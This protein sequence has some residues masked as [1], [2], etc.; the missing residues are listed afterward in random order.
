M[1]AKPANLLMASDPDGCEQLKRLVNGE[2]ATTMVVVLAKT[3]EQDS[4]VNKE[5][6]ESKPRMDPRLLMALRTGNLAMLEQ[7]LTDDGQQRQAVGSNGEEG[8]WNDPSIRAGT[9][10]TSSLRVGVVAAPA[11]GHGLRNGNAGIFSS[12]ELDDYG[13]ANSGE[14]AHH[15]KFSRGSSSGGNSNAGGADNT[16][17]L[18]LNGVTFDSEGDSALHVLAAAG[19]TKQYLKCAEIIYGRAK[20]LLQEIN[21]EDTPVHCAARA[22]NRNMVSCLIEMAASENNGAVR[23]ELLRKRNKI[24]DTSLHSA[25][26]SGNIQLIQMLIW[27]DPELACIPY[28]GTSPLYLAISASELCLHCVLQSF[29]ISYGFSTSGPNGQ[30][31]LHTAVFRDVV[32][33]KALRDVLEWLPIPSRNQLV[34]QADKDGNTPLHYAASK[35]IW[36]KSLSTLF[37][38]IVVGL[39]IVYPFCIVRRMSKEGPTKLLIQASKSSLFKPDNEGSYPIHVAAASGR[40]K[41]VVVMLESFPSCAALRD[42]RGRTFLHVAAEKNKWIIV[43]YASQSHYPEVR[44]VLN[45]QDNNGNTALHLAVEGGNQWVFSYLFRN[46]GVGLDLS[47]KDGLTAIDLAWRKIPEKGRFYHR[48]NPRFFIFRVLVLVRARGI[49]SRTDKFFKED[50]SKIDEG[51]LSDNVTKGSQVMGILA[52]LV[53]SVTFAAA[54]KLP[55]GYRAHGD[56]NNGETPIL[57]GRYAFDAFIIAIA[58]TFICS[59]LATIGL[60]YS[61]FDAVDFTIRMLYFNRSNRLLQS[62]A[63]SLAVA[64]GLGIYLVMFPVAPKIAISVCVIVFEH[65]SDTYHT[66]ET[67]TP[68]SSSPPNTPL[69]TYGSYS[70]YISG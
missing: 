19:D 58:L 7:L 24:G 30:N 35:D 51:R 64:F 26:R 49:I 70:P 53:T 14:D 34:E 29:Q 36:G 54:S 28:D 65:Y 11:T 38:G 50:I 63:R 23:H 12:K 60:I 5:E 33:G 42:R 37:L 17:P 25:I 20:H 45:M 32:S 13:P 46:R 10:D 69:R 31:V 27:E 47:N 56:G 15:H 41:A 4:C 43:G 39:H 61:G 55:G 68:G 8:T 67:R 66:D 9:A 6:E 2:D 18:L 22:G 44:S 16:P 57:A 1:V 59:L 62:S 48:M 40:T 3:E 52:G 21:K